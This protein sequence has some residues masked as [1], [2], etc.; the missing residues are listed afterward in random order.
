MVDSSDVY[1]REGYVR[2][3][4]LKHLTRRYYLQVQGMAR[5]RHNVAETPI[6][7]W[8]GETYTGLQWNPHLTVA[9]GYE[10]MTQE[11]FPSHYF[12]GSVHYRMDSDKS[13]RV[14]VGQQRGA[15][16]CMSGVCRQFAPFEGAKVE[17]VVRF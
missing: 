9:F 6:P 7:W 11:G 16:R 12:N 1:Y 8:E 4:L 13:L 15:L 17:A 10:Y 14:F 2:Y 3:D 5:R